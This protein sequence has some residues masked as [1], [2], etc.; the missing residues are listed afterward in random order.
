MPHM[1]AVYIARIGNTQQ[2]IRKPR[3]I[4]HKL[5]VLVGFHNGFKL[6]RA[7]YVLDTRNGPKKRIH[8]PG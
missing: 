4:R 5:H 3:V 7:E 2:K 8:G 1:H 6:C